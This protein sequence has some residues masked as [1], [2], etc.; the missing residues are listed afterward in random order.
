MYAGCWYEISEIIGRYHAKDEMWGYG[1]KENLDV[2][3][4]HIQFKEY[5]FTW[6]LKAYLIDPYMKIWGS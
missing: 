6:Y 3:C 2:K 4:K 1:Q 5:R